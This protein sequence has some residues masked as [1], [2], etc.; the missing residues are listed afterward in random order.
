MVESLISRAGSEVTRTLEGEAT[1]DG[2]VSSGIQLG[3]A[4]ISVMAPLS[5]P[6]SL[7]L[8]CW[9]KYRHWVGS[10][11]FGRW[12]W[13]V[14]TDGWAA[15][16]W[17]QYLLNT[18]KVEKKRKKKAHTALCFCCFFSFTLW[19]N[20]PWRYHGRACGSPALGSGI[21]VLG[22][23]FFSFQACPPHCQLDLLQA[24]HCVLSPAPPPPPG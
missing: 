5:S 19:R 9:I 12:S 13:E 20:P 24:D 11:A 18:V 10:Y 7:R 1:E 14:I 6:M 15:A 23:F 16:G 8:W 17:K 22:R 2:R 21:D 4:D 3:R